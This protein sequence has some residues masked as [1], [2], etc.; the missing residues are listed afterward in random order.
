MT[1]DALIP[2]ETLRPV[3]QR[4]RR[5]EQTHE[6]AMSVIDEETERRRAKTEK[7][8]AMRLAAQDK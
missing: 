8:K 1:Q 3:D 4:R 2:E 6:I 7:L 5:F